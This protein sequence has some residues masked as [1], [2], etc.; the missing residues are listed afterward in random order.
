MGYDFFQKLLTEDGT[1]LAR[2]IVP[3]SKFGN[4]VAHLQE[5]H[6]HLEMTA[7]HLALIPVKQGQVIPIEHT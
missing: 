7:N 1:P 4:L 5:I 2:A 6:N 3:T